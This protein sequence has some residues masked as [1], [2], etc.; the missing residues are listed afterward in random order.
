MKVV[1]VSNYFNH[2]QKPFS[3]EMYKRLG[4]GYSFI[5]TSPMRDERRALGY[6]DND[7]PDYVLRSYTDKNAE[8]RAK[9]LIC[10]ADAVIVG[11]CPEAL[12]AERIKSGKLT[13]RYSERPFKKRVSLAK[14]LYYSLKWR[15]DA[16]RKNVYML[17]AGSYAFSDFSSIGLYKNKALKWGYFPETLTYDLPQLMAE[18]VKNRILWCGRFIHWKHPETGI[19]LA[20][21]L[22][23]NGYDFSLHFI[24]TGEMEAE[25][26]RQ[27]TEMGLTE[28]VTLCGAMPPQDVR[29]AMESAS[30]FLLTS[31]Q[32]EGWGAV[33]NEAMNSGCAVV[34]SNSAG[35][36]T[37]LAEDGKNSLVFNIENEDELFKK[38]KSLL[39]NPE[40]CA[41]LGEKGYNTITKLWNGKVAA[42][43]FLLLCE[44]IIKGEAISDLFE[45][46]PCSRADK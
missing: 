24:G 22:K 32:Q 19:K 42:E 21:Q 27:I 46:G 13:F 6:C 18:K 29:K 9:E 26:K 28:N 37:Y 23:D 7:E 31:D 2:H 30:V 25:L 14:K 15:G 1:F 10:S 44:S 40:K 11:S 3:E 34:A 5:S 16:R 12:I 36:T 41:K 38:V 43:R 45:N 20:K 4:A 39:D 8:S 33:L 35:A 17:S